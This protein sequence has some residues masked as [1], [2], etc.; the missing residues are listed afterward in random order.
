[1]SDVVK[2]L[3]AK[4]KLRHVTA[5][6]QLITDRTKGPRGKGKAAA[7]LFASPSSTPELGGSRMPEDR[8]PMQPL[9]KEGNASC[10]Y[11]CFQAP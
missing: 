4:T 2:A 10:I 9:S 1:M 3:T 11:P 7:T 6:T 5:K 8:Y